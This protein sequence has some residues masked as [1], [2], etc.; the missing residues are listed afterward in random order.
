MAEA[1]SWQVMSS[2]WNAFLAACAVALDDGEAFD[3]YAAIAT[4]HLGETG[5]RHVDV[6]RMATRAGDRL[7]AGAAEAGRSP[8]SSAVAVSRATVA[9]RLAFSQWRDLGREA[10]AQGIAWSL[11]SLDAG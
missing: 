10:E 5:F 6:A 1:R 2:T 8:E 7:A 3:R 9:Y 11:A 4:E